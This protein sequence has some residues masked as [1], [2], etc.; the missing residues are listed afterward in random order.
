MLVKESNKNKIE[1]MIAEA[2]GRATARTLIFDDIIFDIKEIEKK[3]GIKKKDMIGIKACVDTNAQ[4]FPKAYKYRPE[5]THYT[6]IRKA[7][8]WDLK[9][10][11]RNTTRREGHAYEL[12]LP[13]HTKLAIIKS[14]SNF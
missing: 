1:K 4:D 2:E 14:M 13:K 12:E 11:E 5:S 6:M 8:G 7:N 3:L 10:V 9:T